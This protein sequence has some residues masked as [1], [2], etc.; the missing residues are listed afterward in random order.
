MNNLEGAPASQ[1]D[2]EPQ[3]A[4]EAAPTE[5]GLENDPESS[6]ETPEEDIEKPK[7]EEDVFESFKSVETFEIFLKNKPMSPE[8]KKSLIE[9]F[10]LWILKRMAGYKESND[11]TKREQEGLAISLNIKSENITMPASVIANNKKIEELQKMLDGLEKMQES[12]KQEA[13]AMADEEQKPFEAPLVEETKPAFEDF[14]EE[15]NDA[16]QFEAQDT[17]AWPSSI[18][19]TEGPPT[20]E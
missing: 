2:S 4:P 5:T 1:I 6:L 17:E 16:P 9:K 10:I 11:R 18:S 13:R 3:E 20:F 19:D 7:T 12:P 14:A 15:E 8:K